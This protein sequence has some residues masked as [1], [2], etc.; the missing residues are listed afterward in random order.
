MRRLNGDAGSVA[1]RTV[2]ARSVLGVPKMRASLLDY[3]SECTEATDPGSSR[4]LILSV[5]PLTIRPFLTSGIEVPTLAP[6]FK[7][8][9]CQNVG[10]TA[11]ADGRQVVGAWENAGRVLRPVVRKELVSP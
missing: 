5:V 6:N 8:S 2:E 1:W 11:R 4:P 10:G 3:A 9:A 7:L